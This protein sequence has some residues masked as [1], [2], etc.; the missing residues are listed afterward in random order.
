MPLDDYRLLPAQR[1]RRRIWKTLTY[2]KSVRFP[3]GELVTGT[4]MCITIIS[5]ISFM[6]EYVIAAAAARVFR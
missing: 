3:Y 2:P 4:S 1:W 5:S 6:S